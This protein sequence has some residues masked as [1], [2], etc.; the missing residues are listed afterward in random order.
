MHHQVDGAGI[1]I[2]KKYFL[3]GLAPVSGLVYTTLCIGRKQMTRRNY[4]YMIW[5]FWMYQ[6][7]HNMLRFLQT[8]IL[9]GFTGIHRSINA[10]AAI[11]TAGDVRFTRASPNDIG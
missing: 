6:D 7:T 4:I 1:I 9:P 11:T 10:I 3:P 8:H 5:I 2:D